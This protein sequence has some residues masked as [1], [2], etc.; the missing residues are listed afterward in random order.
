M[1]LHESSIPPLKCL[2]RREF[3]TNNLKHAGQYEKGVAVSVR[4]IPGS[5]ALFQVLL[6]NG[7]LRDKLPI[8]ALHDY[9]HDHVH[10]FHH[11][12]LWNSFSANF[13][14]VEI[15][16]LSGLRVSVRMKDGKWAEGIYLWTMQWGQ[17]TLMALTL[18]WQ[19]I[20]KS[21]RAGISFASTMVNLRSSR[22]TDC[23]GM[24]LVTSQSRF[25]SAQT[26]RS[27]WTNGTAKRTPSGLPR[28]QAHGTTTRCRLLT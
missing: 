25:Q 26:T 15:N 12:Q 10:P 22:I 13:S 28:T 21:T 2:V 4:S 19:S 17:T 7:A 8:H 27:T 14:I 16:F 6:E 23:A 11:L 9:E 18:R 3:L 1:P 24:S 20:P 5:C